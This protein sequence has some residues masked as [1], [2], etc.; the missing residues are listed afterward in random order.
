M[1]T[2]TQ[3]DESRKAQ[4]PERERS[5]CT[6]AK[7]TQ[8]PVA[9]DCCCPLITVASCVLTAELPSMSNRKTPPALE[10]VLEE[11]HLKNNNIGKTRGQAEI[12]A[13]SSPYIQ[14]WSS[15]VLVIVY[16]LL[17]SAPLGLVV[18]QLF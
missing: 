9:T 6:S 11:K 13:I 16:P 14:Q 18:P 7:G 4:T 12:K 1:G 17:Q 2:S 3:T 5:Y 15:S 8:L 10:A